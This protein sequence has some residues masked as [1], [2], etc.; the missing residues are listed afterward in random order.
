M[1]KGSHIIFST[2]DFTDFAFGMLLSGCDMLKSVYSDAEPC[3][4]VIFDFIEDRP[5]LGN[6]KKNEFPLVFRSICTIF[7]VEFETILSINLKT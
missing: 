6:T 5:H 4:S 7:A 3:K 1:A 2:T